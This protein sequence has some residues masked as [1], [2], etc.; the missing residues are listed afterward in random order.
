MNN[1]KTIMQKKKLFLLR[2]ESNPRPSALQ[3]NPL[4]TRLTRTLRDALPSAV[5]FGIRI[6]DRLLQFVHV[7]LPL[8]LTVVNAFAVVTESFARLEDEKR[9]ISRGNTQKN[10]SFG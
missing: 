8:S 3:S 1:S 6:L 4:T 2:Q 5:V 7:D 10:S 9:V